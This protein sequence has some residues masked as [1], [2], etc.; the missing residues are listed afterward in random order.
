MTWTCWEIFTIFHMFRAS[1]GRPKF[2]L[3]PFAETCSSS[4]SFPITQYP[5]SPLSKPPPS[6]TLR[7]LFF[8]SCVMSIC[9]SIDLS[10]HISPGML[11]I[12][13]AAAGFVCYTSAIL[14]VQ[15]V[16]NE[17]TACHPVWRLRWVTNLG[18]CVA[19]LLFP[20]LCA[21]A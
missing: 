11:L 14:L 16:P 9:I 5:R 20:T 13:A 3:P 10:V 6:S 4:S 2:V 17:Y 15:R 12:A 21:N 18:W 8:V 19:R 1:C 7:V